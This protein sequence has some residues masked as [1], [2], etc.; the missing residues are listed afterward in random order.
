MDFKLVSQ[1]VYGLGDRYSRMKLLEGAYGMWSKGGAPL[2]F[3]GRGGL[4]GV[5]PFAMFE[6]AKNR[7]FVGIFF[8]NSNQMTPVVRFNDDGTS[9]LS[10]ITIGGEL[11][12]YFFMQ[13]T[14]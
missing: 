5:H 3:K 13:G 10:F 2:N 12:M 1:N 8:R 4:S 11:E 6:T 14:G 7:R 9:T